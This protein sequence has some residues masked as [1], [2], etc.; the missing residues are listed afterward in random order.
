M[1]CLSSPQPAENRGAFLLGLCQS[2]PTLCLRHLERRIGLVLGAK[3]RL[4]CGQFA[5]L[6]EVGTLIENRFYLGSGSRQTARDVVYLL[7]DA[8]AHR[9]YRVSY[10]GCRGFDGLHHALLE[11]M[12]ALLNGL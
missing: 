2:D 12:S 6:R 5:L 7:T 11:R 3:L 4:L 9:G 8:L 1:G 10:P